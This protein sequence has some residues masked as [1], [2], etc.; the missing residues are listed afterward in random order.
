MSKA[1]NNL[2]QAICPSHH[3]VFPPVT[4]LA[5]VPVC[6]HNCSLLHHPLPQ[7]SLPTM[8]QCI[9]NCASVWQIHFQGKKS[10]V[11]IR[12]L[13]IVERQTNVRHTNWF[14]VL[15]PESSFLILQA[16]SS[17][18]HHQCNLYCVAQCLGPF[19]GLCCTRTKLP[20][21]QKLPTLTLE[22][23]ALGQMKS[24]PYCLLS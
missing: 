4:C 9:P 17:I 21:L 24:I 6:I 15:N 19:W 3:I 16:V 5:A 8:P 12:A 20:I 13:Q 7:I 23:M 2:A 14:Y 1:R 11:L 18:V 10:A 22:G